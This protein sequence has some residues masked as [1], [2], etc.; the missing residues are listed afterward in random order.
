MCIKATALSKLTYLELFYRQMVD[1]AIAIALS[2]VDSRMEVHEK[3]MESQAH[4][5]ILIFARTIKFV[6]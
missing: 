3:L 2:V 4:I 6:H 5:Y 1:F